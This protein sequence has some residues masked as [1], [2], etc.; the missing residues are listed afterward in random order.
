MLPF[1][2]TEG[3]AFPLNHRFAFRLPFQGHQVTLFLMIPFR[4]TA[5]FWILVVVPHL[6]QAQNTSDTDWQELSQVPQRISIVK[7]EAGF[8]WQLTGAGSFYSMGANSFKSANQLTINGVRF[9][10]KKALALD[11]TRFSFIQETDEL[12]ITRD[13]WMDQERSAVRHVDILENKTDRALSIDFMLETDFGYS[14]ENLHSSDGRILG[15]ELGPRDSGVVVKFDARD[16]QSDVFFL[17]QGER[18]EARATMSSDNRNRELAF[19]FSLSLPPNARWALCHWMGQRALV[20]LE[21]IKRTFTPLYQRRRLVRPLLPDYGPPIALRNFAVRDSTAPVAKPHDPDIL[22]ALNRLL[23]RLDF[24][25]AGED[26]LWVSEANQLSGEVFTQGNLKFQSAAGELSLSLNELAALRGGAG[27]GRLHEAYTRD[28]E[29][30]LGEVFLEDSQM[31]GPDGWQMD[32]DAF[33]LQTLL[34][35]IEAEDGLLEESVWA[36]AE[37]DSGDILA[38]TGGQDSQLHFSTPW[39]VLLVP[40]GEVEELAP[41]ALPTA[42]HRLQLTDG[43]QLTGFIRKAAKLELATQ[44]LGEVVVDGAE[45]ALHAFWQRESYHQTDAWQEDFETDW[46]DTQDASH[47]LIW[48]EGGNRLSGNLKGSALHLIAGKTVTPIAP[49]DIL[50][51]RRTEEGILDQVPLFEIELKNGDLLTGQ[52]RE[53]ALEV[54]VREVQWEI[55]TL[56]LLGFRQA[57]PA[58]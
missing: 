56:H 38:L 51:L 6:A 22:I 5:A 32:L 18:A 3:H 20:D 55:P 40:L 43:C 14:W 30:Y 23:E 50:M 10:A 36:F 54:R 24:D 35:R 52:I 47:P 15:T 9:A 57:L 19:Q 46:L 17:I 26:L 1:S 34:F 49:D 16:G 41:V 7:D 45:I 27:N 42:R 53:R 4:R 2:W 25:R 31:K 8:S 39:G 33:S 37:L 11:E 48:L 29:L 28:G 21:G 44:R 13:V 58:S 12:I